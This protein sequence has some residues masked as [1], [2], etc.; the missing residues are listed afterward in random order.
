MNFLGAFHSSKTSALNV[1]QLPVANGTAFSKI[2][3]QGVNFARYSQIFEK[4]FSRSFLAIP[5]GILTPGIFRIFGWIVRISGIQQFPEFMKTFPGKFLYICRC[6]QFFE[7]FGWMESAQK[8]LFIQP[9]IPDISVRNQMERFRFGPTGIF[10]TTFAPLQVVHFD[11]SAHFGRSDR[12][13]PFHLTKLLSPVPLFFIPLTRPRASKSNNQ[14]RGGL[15]WVRATGMYR[16]IGH[17]SC[18]ACA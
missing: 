3:K 17:V 7:S 8:A 14:M 13:V 10:G 11:R 15:G 1:P 18:V 6:F 16:S 2:S 9:K 4:F 5:L 12:N